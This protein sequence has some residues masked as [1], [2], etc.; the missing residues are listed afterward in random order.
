MNDTRTPDRLLSAW[1][2]VEAPASAPDALRTDI[3]GATAEIRPRPAWLARLR[4]NPMDVITGGASRRNARLLPVLALLLIT[5]AAVAAVAFVGSNRRT[6]PA[7]VASASPSSAAP[8]A[9]ARAS[10]PAPSPLADASV[11]LAYPVLELVPGDNAMWATIGGETNRE[12]PRSIVMID[13]STMQASTAVSDIPASRA[14]PISIVQTGGLLWATEN[15]QNHVLKF[16]LAGAL[17]DTIPVGRSPIEPYVAFGEVWSP[18]YD[19]GSLSRIDPVTG[20]VTATIQIEQFKGQGPRD[21]AAGES[22]LWAI[23]PRQDV[24]VGIDR[25]TNAVARE[26]PLEAG[27]H[28][29][30]AVA[31]RHV[32]VSGC[33]STDPIQVFDEATGNPVTITGEAPAIGLP[34]Y[35][36]ERRA[37]IAE[38]D[39]TATHL[40][41]VDPFTLARGLPVIDLGVHPGSIVVGNRSLWYTDGVNVHR[42]SLDRIPSD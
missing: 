9:S 38:D 23:T 2:E 36:G 4:G 5:L 1:F 20:G 35:S 24:L 14:S 8:S 19:D 42:I 18:N 21:L 29:G 40:V 10:A 34:V 33:D 22:L 16:S 37:W 25:R 15:E 12:V 27:L 7:V 11:R 17:L 30:L 13:P 39:G 26:I 31:V 6:P 28:C 3:Y 41:P 32:W